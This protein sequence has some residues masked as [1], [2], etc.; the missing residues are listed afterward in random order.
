MILTASASPRA[1]A[2]QDLRALVPPSCP[3]VVAPSIGEALA[4]AEVAPAARVVCVAGSLA[5]VGAA[6]AHL[7]GPDKPCPVE[8]TADSIGPRS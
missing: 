6:L 1:A 7:D 3:A 2:P 5:L 4:L 8:N